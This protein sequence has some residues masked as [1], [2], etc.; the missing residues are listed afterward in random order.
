[1]SS[2]F[3]DLLIE[4]GINT[5]PAQDKMKQLDKMFDN[6]GKTFSSSI[7][8][9]APKDPFNLGAEKTRMQKYISE[10]KNL[11]AETEAYQK[12]LK[13]LKNQSQFAEMRK[14]L[15][16][17]KKDFIKFKDAE[18]VDKLRSVKQA[19]KISDQELAANTAKYLQKEKDFNTVQDAIDKRLQEEDNRRKKITEGQY[20]R[21]K[22]L[23]DQKIKQAQ[24]VN[25]QLTKEESSV[26]KPAKDSASI[27]QE[28]LD[29]ENKLRKEAEKARLKQAQETNKKITSE[30]GKKSPELQKMADYYKEMEKSSKPLTSAQKAHNNALKQ[31]VQLKEKLNKLNIKPKYDPLDSIAKQNTALRRQITNY[32]RLEKQA[33]DAA[34]AIRMSS[35]Y[36]QMTVPQQSKVEK[37]IA[38]A[39]SDFKITGDKNAFKA[40]NK[41]VNAFKRSLIGLQTVQNGLTDSTRNMVRAYASLFALVEG[42]TAIKNVGMDFQG[43][44]AAMLAS[45]GSTNKAAKD[46]VYINSLADEMGLNL[47]NTADAYV[48]LQFATKGKIEDT[49]VKELF[50]GLAEFGTAL[51]VAPESMKLA[52]RAISQMASKN[53]V[54]AI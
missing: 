29:K 11:G 22:V 53:Q 32:E 35:G 43:M 39:Q 28:Q 10:L 23:H 41:D 15:V 13:G 6:L 48:K 18:S 7:K 21:D 20:K 19:Q 52:Q 3:N 9:N 34:T 33:K 37:R 17:Y 14:D 1:M 24:E 49:Q 4:I 25:K 16:K 38:Q 12:R 47:K 45:A 51:K 54:M 31:Q 44:E 42:T 36:Q 5:K 50:T 30:L 8:K 26:S 40:L 2:T 46:L 27:F